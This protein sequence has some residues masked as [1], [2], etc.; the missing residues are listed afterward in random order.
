MEA[1]ANLEK[2]LLND[3]FKVVTTDRFISLFESELEFAYVI[4]LGSGRGFECIKYTKKVNM[5]EVIKLQ[6]CVWGTDHPTVKKRQHYEVAS[7]KGFGN[8]RH[9][10]TFSELNP[11]IEFA[12]NYH[13]NLPADSEYVSYWFSQSEVITRVTTITEIVRVVSPFDKTPHK[14]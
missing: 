4:Y 10:E 14:K 5:P 2:T 13:N 12:K 6:D 9:S 1:F 7:A 3:N 11:A 8:S